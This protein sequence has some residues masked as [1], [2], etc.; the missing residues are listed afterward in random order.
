MRTLLKY[1]NGARLAPIKH[2]SS[3]SVGYPHLLANGPRHRYSLPQRTFGTPKLAQ[4]GVTFQIPMPLQSPGR[5][6]HVKCA[7]GW[8]PFIIMQYVGRRKRTS[9]A[10]MTQT[11][12]NST[13]QSKFPDLICLGS[14]NHRWEYDFSQNQNSWRQTDS[15]Y[16]IYK[17]NNRDPLTPILQPANISHQASHVIVD[18]P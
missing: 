9:N 6:I 5:M 10:L 15:R 16:T 1:T 4:S 3:I 11:L 18:T 13:D 12:F 17:P 8:D 14:K 7:H 2:A